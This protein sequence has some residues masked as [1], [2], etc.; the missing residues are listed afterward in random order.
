MWKTYRGKSSV[1][2]HSFGK[3]HPVAVNAGFKF[4][5]ELLLSESR[6]PWQ[7]GP[8][9]SLAAEKT[10][11]NPVKMNT[12][13]SHYLRNSFGKRDDSSGVGDEELSRV[14]CYGAGYGATTFGTIAE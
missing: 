14:F 3:N 6:A 13:R 8:G 2:D 9:V 7:E 10:Y 12:E 1:V 11:K 5:D 4:L